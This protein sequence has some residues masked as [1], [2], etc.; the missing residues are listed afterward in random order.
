MS[1]RQ[2]FDYEDDESVLPI[3]CDRRWYRLNVD[4]SRHAEIDKK[5]K[6]THH[7]R[8]KES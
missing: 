2:Y 3:G 7:G 6:R 5:H 1:K 8:T 4:T